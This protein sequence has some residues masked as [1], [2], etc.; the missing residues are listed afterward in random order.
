MVQAMKGIVMDEEHLDHFRTLGEWKQAIRERARELIG[1]GIEPIVVA[2]TV[3]IAATAIADECLDGDIHLFK[4]MH[5]ELH[6][7]ERKHFPGGGTRTQKTKPKETAAPFSANG[8][9]H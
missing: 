6:A 9:T 4:F 8:I 3:L 1:E 7:V 2:R 5:D